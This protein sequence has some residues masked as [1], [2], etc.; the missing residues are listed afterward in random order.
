MLESMGLELSTVVLSL[1]YLLFAL[2][3]LVTFIV[4]WIRFRRFL[5]G[6]WRYSFAAAGISLL[7]G[8]GVLVILILTSDVPSWLVGAAG[9]GEVLRLFRLA[10]FVT[11]GVYYCRRIGCRAFALVPGWETL[12]EG[13]VA[14]PAD[15]GAAAGPFV[16]ISI[17]LEPSMPPPPLEGF[18]APYA[19]PIGTGQPTV[20]S[21]PAVQEFRK[22][23]E[24][25]DEP[26][27]EHRK[28]DDSF[29]PVSSRGKIIALGLLVGIAAVIGTEGLFWLT[30][31]QISAFFKTLSE[32]QSELLNIN[33]GVSLMALLAFAT[34]AYFEEL[35]FRLGIQNYLAGLFGRGRGR[36]W[37]A[38]ALT[39]FVWALGHAGMVDPNWVK[40]LQIFAIGLSLGWL[41][42]KCGIEACIIAHCVLNLVSPFMPYTM[43]NPA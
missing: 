29:T 27:E 23:P 35:V 2:G 31:P 8:V 3:F 18:G 32:R 7:M 14:P 28:G 20:E 19:S 24:E 41:F 37:L 33:Q 9:F 26:G 25:I 11:L 38:I 5:R 22:E 40:M 12:H 4:D 42:R 1:L 30:R 16:P 34:Y 15:S 39:S 13:P 10:L 21:P 43:L 17:G 36:Y 6:I